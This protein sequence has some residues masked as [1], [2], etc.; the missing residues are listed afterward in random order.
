M[1]VTVQKDRSVEGNR[2]LSVFVEMQLPDWLSWYKKPEYR[3]I[4]EYASDIR[5]GR[6]QL[7]PDGRGKT[8]IPARL[9]LERVLENKTCRFS[10]AYP[11]PRLLL[12][13]PGAQG[14]V[15][16]S[17]RTGSPM[18]LYDFYMYLRH[19]ELS[20]ENLEFYVWFKNYERE[21]AK[22]GSFVGFGE[23]DEASSVSGSSDGKLSC[24]KSP[25]TSVTPTL[26]GP[27]D[28][29]CDP[30]VGK[31]MTQCERPHDHAAN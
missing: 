13:R 23:K 12:R 29:D 16:D 31:L 7:S 2:I 30:E 1:T 11:D 17:R 5:Q 20:P 8:A 15:A 24:E 26:R 4:K 6:R 19:I 21:Y 25:T 10:L 18:S 27:D 28:F 9:R 14:S 22:A 3:D